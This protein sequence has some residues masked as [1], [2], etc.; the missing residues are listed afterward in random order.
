MNVRTTVNVV[1]ILVGDLN[2]EFL[3]IVSTVSPTFGADL[4]NL[5]NGHHNLDSVKRVQAEIVGEVRCAG[6]L[7]SKD[8]FCNRLVVELCCCYLGGILDLY[9]L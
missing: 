1:G 9:N 7:R 3:R 6:N 2:A 4:T 5:F 8:Q